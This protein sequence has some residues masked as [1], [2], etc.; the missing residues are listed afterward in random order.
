MRQANNGKVAVIIYHGVPD[1]EHPA[2][3]LDPAIFKLQMQYLK[4]NN[5]KVIALRDLAQYI[6]PAKAAQPPPTSKWQFKFKNFA[7]S[8]ALQW[9][10]SQCC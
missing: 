10:D 6:D 4:D 2:V 3:S 8:H 1:I 7:F 9:R 5:Y